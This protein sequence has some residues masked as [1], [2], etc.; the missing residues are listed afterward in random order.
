MYF[1]YFVEMGRWYW[2]C[3]KRG[4]IL[5]LLELHYI[6]V[7]SRAFLFYFVSCD[8]NVA[9][10]WWCETEKGGPTRSEEAQGFISPYIPKKIIQPN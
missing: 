9:A 5:I 10:L 2:Y 3:F 7:K 6:A 1:Y 4:S 8:I